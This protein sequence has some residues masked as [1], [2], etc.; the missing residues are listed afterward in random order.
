MKKK[1]FAIAL[2]AAVAAVAPFLHMYLTSA[3]FNPNRVMDDGVFNNTGTMSAG[4]IDA[5][6]NARNSC[7][8]PQ[9][10]F[11][12]VDPIGYSPGGGYQYGG[13]ETAGTVI[14]HAAQAYDL[15]PQVLIATLQKEQSLI[16]ST[17]CSTNTIAKA[18][19]YACPDSGGS[20][21][22]SGINLYTRNGTTY[23]SVSG[24]CVNS[25]AKAGFTQQVIRAAW[26]LKFAQQRSLGNINW[27]IVRGNWDNS[28]DRQSCYSGPVTEGYRQVCPSG[29]TNYYDGLR[30]IDGQSV[31]M[32]TGATAALYW[33]TPHFHGNQNFVSIFESWFG[34]TQSPDY[35]WQVTNQ[36][37]YGDNTKAN[38][39]GWNATLQTD[40]TAYVV[41]KVKN[42][43]NLTWEKN[44]ANPVR[45]GTWSEQDRKSAF[46]YQ[47]L[48]CNR[49]AAPLEDTVVPGETATFEFWVKASVPGGLHDEKFNLVAEGKSWFNNAGQYVRFDVRPPTFTWSTLWQTVYTDNTK[50]NVL[51][52]DANVLANQKFYVVLTVKNTGNVT[53]EKNGANPVR[54]GTWHGQDRNSEFCQ[55]AGWL[56]CNRIA[57]PNETSVPPGGTATY[58]FWMQTPN[59]NGNFREYLNLVAE[60]RSWMN[61][62]GMF[63]GVNASAP[64]YN[65]QPQHQTVYTDSNKTTALGWNATLSTNQTAYVVMKVKNTSNV[66]WYK[67]STTEPNV[68]LGT[69]FPQDR[70]SA[71]CYQWLMCNR[72]ATHTE[73]TVAPGGIATFEFPVRAPAVP[74]NYSEYFNM[75]A[76]G[77][78]WMDP[79]GTYIK[80]T[81]Q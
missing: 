29:P 67:N 25:A 4:D 65:W 64:Q 28:D 52:W 5:F 42:T 68:R 50:S 46:C 33:Y 45:L 81:V 43:G 76:D 73:S 79:Q 22:Y 24:I 78:S 8:S 56:S 37:V 2:V 34:G 35:S 10:G 20:Y 69:W 80:F 53:W 36:T 75:V 57:S 59:R 47:W 51:G 27:A 19:G 12:A 63:I 15:N 58:E 71:F 48:A 6:L 16:T 61:P 7:I 41:L 44:G 18:M 14:L 31:H 3:A 1:I 23:T 49:P 62:T 21:S 66:T 77:K 54:L 70:N 72:I 60:G 32:D 39:L 17:S 13:N 9:S 55:G 11:R 26:L 74:G 38:V 30:T 40:Q